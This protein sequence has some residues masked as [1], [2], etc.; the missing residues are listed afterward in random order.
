M[1]SQMT[2]VFF[3]L[4]YP[5]SITARS[6]RR[7]NQGRARTACCGAGQHGTRLPPFSRAHVTRRVARPMALAISTAA[8]PRRRPPV[9]GFRVRALK[10]PA[11][12]RLGPCRGRAAL[13][14]RET[15]RGWERK[16]ELCWGRVRAVCDRGGGF[17]EGSNYSR[18]L[19][20]WLAAM[21]ELVIVCPRGSD[22]PII[23]LFKEL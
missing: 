20:A 4:Q 12:S 2:S 16:R 3:R 17:C 1:P 18:L 19:C 5:A 15:A 13:R 22:T 9:P 14:F 10:C 7:R 6:S 11:A 8:Y 23:S 21:E